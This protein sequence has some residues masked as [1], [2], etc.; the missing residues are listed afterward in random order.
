MLGALARGGA[1]LLKLLKPSSK[2]S[3]FFTEN[4]KQGLKRKRKK[5]KRMV[6]PKERRIKR[7]KRNV[8]LGYAGTAAAAAG[9]AALHDVFP[10]GPI[11]KKNKRLM[12]EE[13]QRKKDKAKKI[14]AKKKKVIKYPPPKKKKKK[15]IKGLEVID[16]NIYPKK[17][18]N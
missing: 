14:K 10:D 3:R 6:T 2:N 12:E 11:D 8:A 9:G 5:E 13:K 17:K 7:T 18:R 4:T 15:T 1:A 16:I